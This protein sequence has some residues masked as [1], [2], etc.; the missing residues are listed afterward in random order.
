MSHTNQHQIVREHRAKMQ[1][2]GFTLIELLVVIAI[3]AILSQSCSLFLRER[4]K[5]RGG[6]VV[7]RT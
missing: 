6:P 5:T 2:K 1:A 3:I 7:Y 4:V